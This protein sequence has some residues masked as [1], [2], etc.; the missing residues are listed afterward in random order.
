MWT[1]FTFLLFIIT[2]FSKHKVDIIKLFQQLLKRKSTTIRDLLNKR[3]LL[4][5]Q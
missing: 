3:S 5:E 4:P 2:N 1:V